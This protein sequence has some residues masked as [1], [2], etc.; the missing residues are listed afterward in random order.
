MSSQPQTPGHSRHSTIDFQANSVG[1]SPQGRRQSRSSL[2]DP[3]TPLRQSFTQGDGLDVFSS[4]GMGGMGG[5]G[6]LGNLADELAD[7]LSDGEDDEYYDDNTGAP[8]V[9]FD[10]QEAGTDGV[11]GQRDSGVD[12]D[13][14]PKHL[15]HSKNMSLS[16]PSPNHGRH[17][18]AGSEYDGSEYGSE[19][20]LDSPSMPPSLVA[21]IDAVESLAR[22][23]TENNGSQTDGVFTRVT[24]SLRDLGSQS[25]VEGGA[26]RLITAHSALTTHLTHQTRQVQTLAFPLL[27]PLVAPP[28]PE[29]IEEILPLLVSLSEQMPR[30]STTAYNSLSGLH[31][32]TNDLVQTLNYLSDTLHMSRQTSIT[33]T[34]RLKSAKELVAEM[35]QEEE[36]REEGERWIAKGNWGERLKNRECAHICGEVVGGFEEVCNSWRARLLAQ[37]EGAQA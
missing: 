32:L 8:D 23:G 19:S 7:A 16:L 18:R 33:A 12:V 26:T 28:D 29:T 3:G 13:P 24:D 5:G 34:R 6:G 9:S 10:V 15:T 22:R 1:S 4:G 36:L 21:K 30:P 14:S 25:G 17:R 11:E 2:Q 27:S 35:R 20:D 37:A 31:T